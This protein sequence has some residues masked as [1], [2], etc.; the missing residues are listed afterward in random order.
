V[1][2]TLKP[3]AT[4]NRRLAAELAALGYPEFSHLPE[5]RRN[6]AEVLLE[7][8]AQNDLARLAEALPWV[9]LNYPDLNWNWLV[10]RVKA[11]DLQNRLGFVTGGGFVITVLYGL[12]RQTADV[13]FLS[14]VPFDQ[15]RHLYDLAL[16]KLERDRDDVKFQATH[17]PLDSDKLRQRKCGH[18]YRMR[19]GTTEP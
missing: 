5:R 7:A 18:T 10:P 15:M 9:V 16:S 14:A 3:P 1:S 2:N 11:N 8:L 6:P 12:D 4:T 13:D 17:L 19:V